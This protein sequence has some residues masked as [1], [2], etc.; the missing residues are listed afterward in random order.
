MGKR[1]AVKEEN[2]SE[3]DRIMLST[4]KNTAICK[5]PFLFLNARIM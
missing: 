5:A 4:F 2:G 3:A 1:A